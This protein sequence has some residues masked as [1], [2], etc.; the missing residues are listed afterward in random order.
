MLFDLEVV[1]PCIFCRIKKSAFLRNSGSSGACAVTKA[2]RVNEICVVVHSLFIGTLQLY[3]LSRKDGEARNSLR[4]DVRLMKQTEGTGEAKVPPQTRMIFAI[5]T[6]P[7]SAGR[8]MSLSCWNLGWMCLP[9][10]RFHI[11]PVF[12]RHV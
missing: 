8:S 11:L 2:T 9:R 4:C 12:H 5:A 1:S 3:M 7:I 10:Q 6:H